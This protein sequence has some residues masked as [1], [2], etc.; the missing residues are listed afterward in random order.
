MNKMCLTFH[1]VSKEFLKLSHKDPQIFN[2]LSSTLKMLRIH[3]LNISTFLSRERLET[4]THIKNHSD[5]GQETSTQFPRHS[6]QKI[7]RA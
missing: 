4:S 6:R 1:S 2:Q 3:H 7:M 5:G